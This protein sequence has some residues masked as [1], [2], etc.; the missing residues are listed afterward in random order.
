MF[1][2]QL[3]VITLNVHVLRTRFALC[4]GEQLAKTPEIEASP[5]ASPQASPLRLSPKAGCQNAWIPQGAKEGKNDNVIF[6]RI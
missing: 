1:S 4:F 5:Q 3:N 2:C 6:Q